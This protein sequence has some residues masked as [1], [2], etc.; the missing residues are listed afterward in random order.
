MGECC[1]ECLN[2]DSVTYSSAIRPFYTCSKC[3]TE[4]CARHINGICHKC[5]EIYCDSCRGNITWYANVHVCKPCW[6]TLVVFKG[7]HYEPKYKSL[8][9]C[10][11]N[12]TC[13][14]YDLEKCLQY[15]ISLVPLKSEW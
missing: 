10:E 11:G 2:H 1:R 9:E 6:N 3:K 8:H 13:W 15:K 12:C 7:D 5:K 4:A 14:I